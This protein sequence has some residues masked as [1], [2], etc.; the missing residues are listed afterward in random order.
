LS[1][2]AQ[3]EI[4]ARPRRALVAPPHRNGIEDEA[5]LRR[6]WA[7]WDL[8]EGVRLWP[9]WWRQSWGEVRRR[10]K[11]TLLGPAWVTVSLIIFAVAT[12]FVWAGLFQQQVS[13]ALPFLLSGLLSWALISTCLGDGCSLF[14]SAEGLIKSRQF[15]YTSLL[16]AGV[17]RNIIILGHN[18]A[19]YF[20]VAAFCGVPVGWQTLLLVP[21]VVLVVVNCIWMEMVIAVLCIR[22]RDFQQ[23][24]ASLLQVAVFVTPIFWQVSQ[25]KG[26][27]AII[28]HGN[29]LH[30]M[31]D[32]I[33]QPLLG[34]VPELR[35]YVI[36]VVT[37]AVGMLVAFHFYASKR[38]R[39]AY[40]F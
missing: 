27:R 19:G 3:P 21:G 36:C 37:A 1:R 29:P 14:T 17:T 28:A 39:L 16:Y 10:Y 4:G 9:M 30:H 7:I 2:S 5:R 38:H 32:I 40:W 23:L 8:V 15:P 6:E 20:L 18:L 12:S 26:K 13:Q 24:V 22:F 11:R 34:N 25:L 35:S 31:V 33:R